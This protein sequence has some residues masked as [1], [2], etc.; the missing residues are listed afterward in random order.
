M[1][2][3]SAQIVK[4]WSVIAMRNR[5]KNRPIIEMM[6]NGFT[7]TQIAKRTGLKRDELLEIEY[8]A[9]LEIRRKTKRV[10]FLDQAKRNTKA[11][12]FNWR[13]RA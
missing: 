1:S 13:A 8:W 10:K 12:P 2:I 11:D 4:R 5:E 9:G 7:I 3:F 6:K